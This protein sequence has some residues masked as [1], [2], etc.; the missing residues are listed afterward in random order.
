MYPFTKYLKF[1]IKDVKIVWA[2]SMKGISSPP[3]GQWTETAA[4]PLTLG[5]QC[6]FS[7]RL[8]AIDCLGAIWWRLVM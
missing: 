5:P 8:A 1:L 4:I 7:L 2:R 3:P 6:L